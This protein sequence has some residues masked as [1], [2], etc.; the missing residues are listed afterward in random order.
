M[1]M[2]RYVCIQCKCV[3]TCDVYIY[4]HIGLSIKTILEALQK[5]ANYTLSHLSTLVLRL[6]C[7]FMVLITVYYTVYLR[8][9]SLNRSG[10]GLH[11][12][13]PES[14]GQIIPSVGSL[15][16][17]SIISMYGTLLLNSIPSNSLLASH[18]GMYYVH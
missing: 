8:I 15:R 4:V 2:C 6:T 17:H 18:T 11:P 3:D 14:M 16:D 9:S 12:Y 13:Y 5:G 7:M 1:Y 10:T